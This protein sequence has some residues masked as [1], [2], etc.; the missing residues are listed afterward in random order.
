MVCRC[1]CS[2]IIK[3]GLHTFPCFLFFFISLLFNCSSSEFHFHS[4][5]GDPALLHAQI[6]DCGLEMA[7][8]EGLDLPQLMTLCAKCGVSD[9]SKKSQVSWIVVTFPTFPFLFSTYFPGNYLHALNTK[10]PKTFRGF[11]DDKY[12]TS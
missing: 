9:V 6:R 4:S 2:T 7:S 12:S 11:I 10:M 3:H 1:V 8:I 5:I